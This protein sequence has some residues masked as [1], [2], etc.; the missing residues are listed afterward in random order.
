MNSIGP[1][2][3]D[4]VLPAGVTVSAAAKRLG[5]GRPALSNF[6]NGKAA[7]SKDMALR[8]EREFGAD[9]NDLIRRQAQVESDAQDAFRRKT[10]ERANAAGY[11]KITSTDI[12][13]WA[14]TIA[15]RTKFPV[16]MRRLAHAD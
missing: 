6:L 5:V 16:L 14:G 8:I 13:N 4:N 3:R 2:V 7:L 15:A 12:A 9:A 11:L 1:Y 10:E